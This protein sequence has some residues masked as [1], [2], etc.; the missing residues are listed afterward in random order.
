MKRNSIRT[1]LN[2]NNNASKKQLFFCLS[3]Y[4]RNFLSESYHRHYN[5]IN[6]ILL[7]NH[8]SNF[9][10]VP[11]ESAVTT[12]DGQD[13][14]QINN[15]LDF[16]ALKICIDYFYTSQLKVPCHLLSHVYT[17]AY[18]LSFDSIVN[19]CA[20]YLS[21]H[22]NV[23]NCLSIRSFALDENLIQSSSECIEKNIEY[24]L[25]IPIMRSMSSSMS[26]LNNLN[27]KQ[28]LND[29]NI[30]DLTSSTMSLSSANVAN[31]EFNHLPRINIEL[32]GM[33]C[34]KYKLPENLESLTELC[35]G[36]IVDDLDPKKNPDQTL[37][38]LC[39][40]LNM[41]YMNNEDNTLHDCS[42]MD[43][44]DANFND[45]INDY[46]RQ[47]TVVKDCLNGLRG[48]RQSPT[49]IKSNSSSPL[50]SCASNKLKT[51][52]ITDQELNAVGTA[53][54]I[55][56]KVLHDNEVI[57][58]HQTNE[59]SF[60]TI[61][62]L[63]GKL[64]TLSVHVLPSQL[65]KD[66]ESYVNGIENKTLADFD[67]ETPL[68][69]STQ[70]LSRLGISDPSYN[71][72]S[73]IA[74]A[75][76]RSASTN[77]MGDLEKIK[78]GLEKMS[79]MFVARCSHG[80]IA[81]EK[82]LYIIGGYDRGECLNLCE[83]YDPMNNTMNQM[84]QMPNRRGRAA[85]TWF[86]GKKSIFVM[87]GSNGHEDLNSIECYDMVKKH[88]STIKF[89]FEIDC[90]N[91]ATTACD[92][93]IYLVGLK[94]TANQSRISCL[95]YDPNTNSFSRLAE[96]NHGRSQSAI[97]CIPSSNTDNSH[98]NHLLYVFGGYDKIRCLNSCE[99]YNPI[100]DRWLMLPSMHE[101]RRGCGAVYHKETQSIYIVGGTNGTQSL[102]SV[103]IFNI[104]TK[105]WTSGPELNTART[106]VSIAFIGN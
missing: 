84:E 36:W 106:N 28:G 49:Y 50:P 104:A 10:H 76:T 31:Q 89:D 96:L 33:N 21:K 59:S 87:G 22:L 83:I 52:K 37:E 88:W 93:Y 18:H 13:N 41:L 91:S 80:L 97:V 69:L 78:T 15:N 65:S 79:K 103:E 11:A 68:R 7:N 99:V 98:N 57:C 44:D 6:N 27:F 45:N 72:D 39:D 23:N 92:S 35:M 74:N 17:L 90:S 1:I 19:I 12:G 86:E 42:D 54:P 8:S 62:T 60:I 14:K 3:D 5:K 105:K 53:T 64:V 100:E 101:P 32:V 95:K 61:C 34:Q 51:F 70:D 75:I 56:L 58:S 9:N 71:R 29:V 81:F 20:E 85:I 16:E 43:S 46:Q 2:K 67:V 24:I 25:Q 47:Y 55:R 30:N 63:A 94:G 26:S 102:R 4:L 73:A 66:L 38:H 48:S 77:S 82:K 40:N